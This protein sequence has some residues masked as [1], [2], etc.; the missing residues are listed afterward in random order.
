M[1]KIVNF[2]KSVGKFFERILESGSGLSSKRL[3]GLL[4]WLTLLGCYSYAS[5]KGTE[6]PG[7]TTEFILGTVTLLGVDSVTGIWRDRNKC[8]NSHQTPTP[9]E[10]PPGDTNTAIL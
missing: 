3:C 8:N 1:G 9:P 5:W 10:V 4:G 6:L 7:C 2:F